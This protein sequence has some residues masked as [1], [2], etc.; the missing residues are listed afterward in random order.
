M[1]RDRIG[2]KLKTMH[3]GAALLN[4]AVLAAILA[5]LPASSSAQAPAAQVP[6]R[7]ATPQNA[8]SAPQTISG[9][10]QPAFDTVQRTLDG[11]HIDK[12]KKG[13]I[14]DEASANIESIRKD[15]RTNIP[16]LLQEADSG[17]GTV[18]KL[19]PLSN[20]F[21]ALYDVLL[22]VSEASRVSGPDDQATQLQQALLSLNKARLALNERVQG[23]ADA[24]EKQAADLRATIQQQ[25]AQ[26]AAAP[27]PVAL[28]CV[29]A[30]TKKLAAK[31][32]KPAAKPATTPA[33][34]TT[35][36][37]A[38]PGPSH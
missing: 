14:R 4:A 21:D 5:S 24:L 19:L 34:T 8:G 30:P 29:P 11:V 7:P 9:L 36:T 2:G 10:L 37:L 25:A 33:A 3:I 38:K 31:T 12:W 23:S 28:P 13:S 32:H 35:T 26:R 17:P 6:A 1:D 20:H 18:G 16:Q 15:L 22:R 27:A